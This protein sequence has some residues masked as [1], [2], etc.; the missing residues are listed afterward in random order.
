MC[1]ATRWHVF[2][3][4]TH[5]CRIHTSAINRQFCRNLARCRKTPFF[6]SIYASNQRIPG[7][8]A[9]QGAINSVL[10]GQDLLEAATDANPWFGMQDRMKKQT[11]S[12]K[13]GKQSSIKTTY[14]QRAEN[15]DS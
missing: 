12:R 4:D 1:L 3:P 9:A 5:A 11:R 7:I 13:D 6:C 10:I 2:T 15:E 8:N 14:H